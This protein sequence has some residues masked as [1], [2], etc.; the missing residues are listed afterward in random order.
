MLTQYISTRLLSTQAWAPGGGGVSLA[1]STLIALA[2]RGVVVWL[3]PEISCFG[4][5]LPNRDG[6]YCLYIGYHYMY[7]YVL[8]ILGSDTKSQQG[9]KYYGI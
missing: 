5:Q 6:S 4:V 8:H 2:N 9:K 1:G 7:H 3:G